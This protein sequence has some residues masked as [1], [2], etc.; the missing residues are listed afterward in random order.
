[1]SDNTN[2]VRIGG[3]SGIAMIL[4]FAVAILLLP[5]TAAGGWLAIL[6]TLLIVPFFIG[7]YFILRDS[8]DE[9]LIPTAFELIGVV[10]LV[11]AYLVNAEFLYWYDGR[12]A[13]ASGVEQQILELGWAVRG[14]IVDEL[15]FNVG[16]WLT[17][18]L[19]LFLFALFGWRSKNVP[20]WIHIVGLIAIVTGF[21]WL[22]PWPIPVGLGVLR[23]LP[24][25]LTLVIWAVGIGI[26]MV[27]YREGGEAGD[28]S[29]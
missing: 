22:T 15:L 2:L 5:G 1:M 17:M 9:V 13:G 7:V 24:S 16:S 26:V 3:W 28:S 18:S 19:S 23:Q 25:F 14:D 12:I 10:F 11:L 29:Q 8:G 27:R 4:L 21:G 6:G 20:R